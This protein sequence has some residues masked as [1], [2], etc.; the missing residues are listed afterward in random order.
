MTEELKITS[1]EAFKINF[2][3]PE[4]K[5]GAL[6]S[7]KQTT[8]FVTILTNQGISG[9]G[10]GRYLTSEDSNIKFIKEALEPILIGQ[11][12]F[13]ILQL[14]EKMYA[15]YRILLA[16]I[17]SISSV[18]IALWD[19]VG[20]YYGAPI[21]KLLGLYQEEI[22]V[23][24]SGF[25]WSDENEMI[26][27]VNSWKEKGFKGAKVRIGR[28][29][30]KDI[31]LIKEM[32]KSV[33]DD[34]DIMVDANNNYDFQTA[35]RVAEELYS[36][37]VIWLE[38]PLKPEWLDQYSELRKRT[39]MAIAGGEHNATL[40]QFHSI[41]EK[42]A[43]DIIQPD[44]TR[45][46]GISQVKKIAALAEAYGKI[47]N[48]HSW[49]SAL[50]VAVNLQV[51]ATLPNCSYMEYPMLPDAIMNGIL[52]DAF[53]IRNGM[54]SVPGNPGIGVKINKDRINEYIGGGKFLK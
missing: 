34:F 3:L 22:P 38:E 12:P 7:L 46:G 51:A 40:Y 48:V 31:S 19:L 17:I 44:T 16:P 10:F 5:V 30:I 43:Y 28:D 1:I 14:W 52:E 24:A 23:Y 15:Y 41:L 13:R 26:K 29:P 27:D 4:I 6:P 47:T 36:L 35:V 45:C 37:G 8:T 11:S 20:K 33:G 39:K 42:N 49:G 32:R 2:P 50:N 54:I 25:R 9:Y 18:E 21:S 53:F